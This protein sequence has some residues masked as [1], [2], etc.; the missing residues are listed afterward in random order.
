MKDQ[1]QQHQI[2]L[3][4]GEKLRRLKEK[5]QAQEAKLAKIRM[6]CGQVESN[7]YF[8]GFVVFCSTYV[9]AT[10]M[11]ELLNLTIN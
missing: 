4:E 11:C 3:N 6:M 9:T 1:L 7:R 2:Q 10:S 8:C 5:A